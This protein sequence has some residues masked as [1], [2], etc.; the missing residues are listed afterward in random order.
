MIKLFTYLK[1]EL[2]GKIIEREGEKKER[3]R[4]EEGGAAAKK[5]V[6]GKEVGE[7]FI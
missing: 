1:K 6:G 2:V 4:K 7:E 5:C 3:E